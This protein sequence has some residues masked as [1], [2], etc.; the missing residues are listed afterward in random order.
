MKLWKQQ[1]RILL[2]GRMSYYLFHR[3]K[4]NWVVIDCHKIPV[5]NIKSIIHNIIDHLFTLKFI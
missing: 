4:L 2:K 3:Y 5:I 1:G